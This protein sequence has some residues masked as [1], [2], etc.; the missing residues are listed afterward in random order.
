MSIPVADS[1][2]WGFLKNK[3]IF[4]DWRVMPGHLSTSF[5]VHKNKDSIIY[6]I[7]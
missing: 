5:C 1:Q 6:L 4:G 7:H 2:H 3:Y